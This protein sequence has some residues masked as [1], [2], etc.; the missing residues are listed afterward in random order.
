MEQNDIQHGIETAWHGL[1]VIKTSEEMAQ[2]GFP[3]EVERA[4]LF[5]GIGEDQKPLEG[6]Y[7]IRGTDD[8]AL[9]GVPQYSSYNFLSM[10]AFMDL[11]RE[12]IKGTGAK[13]ESL[14]TFASRAK[15]YVSLRVGTEW[16]E[17]KVGDRAF[18]NYL[19]LMDSLDGTL[20]LIA[21]ASNV[22]VVCANTFGM[23]LAEKSDFRLSNRHSKNHDAP[24]RIANFQN[25]IDAYHGASALFK[26]MMES[27]E[28]VKV[29]E[30]TAR[31]VL[32]GYQTEGSEPST[33]TTNIVDRQVTLFKTGRGN[34]GQTAADLISGV[35]DYY[36]HESS[37][38]SRGVS[39]QLMSSEIGAGA[40][41]K[42]EFVEAI[43]MR[44]PTAWRVDSKRIK[45]LADLGEK[46][47][48]VVGSNSAN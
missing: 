1:T 5:I 15:R 42:R 34:N 30:E 46:A 29:D 16:D 22:C 44:T 47:L 41:A 2:D 33:R 45:A 20:P 38:E 10:T 7:H 9:I 48:T 13:V 26:K 14:G 3:F 32:I 12:T 17:F 25:A 6:Y 21:K 24:E 31:R 28:A 8:K 36:T 35:T 23:S 11:I 18:K 40:K 39:A 37:S 4:P 43:T 27:A 19:N